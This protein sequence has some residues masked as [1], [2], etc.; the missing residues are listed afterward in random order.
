MGDILRVTEEPEK[1]ARLV[2]VG[3]D[4]DR[5]AAVVVASHGVAQV[6]LAAREAPGVFPVPHRPHAGQR[7][8]RPVDEREPL[9]GPAGLGVGYRSV[10][11]LR[12]MQCD[13]K[14]TRFGVDRA[15]H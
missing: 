4:P 11:A 6:E 9:D 15:F 3:L 5:L 2:A 13:R 8:P 1:L 7:G 12:V 10:L 14:L